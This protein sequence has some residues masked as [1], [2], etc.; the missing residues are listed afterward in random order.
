M[1]RYACSC[2]MKICTLVHKDDLL[3]PPQISYNHV[4]CETL[5]ALPR[6]LIVPDYVQRDAVLPRATRPSQRN[7][8]Y[9][10]G[11]IFCVIGRKRNEDFELVYGKRPTSRMLHALLDGKRGLSMASSIV[12]NRVLRNAALR[13]DSGAITSP[14]ID[15]S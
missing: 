14:P 15:S 5:S 8:C 2:S 7:T 11:V 6:M 10:R 13:F 3:V 1:P 9:K 4:L 12:L